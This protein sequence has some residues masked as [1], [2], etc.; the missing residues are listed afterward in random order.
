MRAAAD[1]VMPRVC[2]VCGRPLNLQEKHICLPCKLNLPYTHFELMRHNRMADFYNERLQEK[3]PD[4]YYPYQWAIALFRYHRKSPYSHI[5]W[6]LKYNGNRACG[7][8]FARML[9]EKIRETP[10]LSDVDLIVPVP[11]HFLRHYKRGYNQAEV[12]A[13]EVGREL[14][15]RV[16]PHLLVKKKFTKSQVKVDTSQRGA[17]IS[18]TFRVNQKFTS[19]GEMYHILIVDDVFTTGSTLSECHKMIRTALK[20]TIRISVATLCCAE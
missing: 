7:R 14:G 2:V 12:I 10:W 5:P 17:N 8:Y 1:I 18:G 11:V 4:E 20:K 13:R 9:A 15:V 19:E 6:A 3:L 16:E